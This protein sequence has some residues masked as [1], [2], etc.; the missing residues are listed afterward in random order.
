M[1]GDLG[2]PARRQKHTSILTVVLVTQVVIALLTATAVYVGW[3]HLD[4]NLASGARIHHTRTK[5]V[6][7]QDRT[8]PSE[9][10]NVLVLGTD[11]RSGAGDKLDGEAGCDCS[12]TTIL[13]HV[14]AD[15]RSAYGVSIP[16]DALVKPVACTR[17]HEYLG[18]GLV[19]WN[20]AYS[21]GGP[22]CVADQLEQDFHVY[23]DDY[24]V[25][26]FN[27]FTSMVDAI[28]GVNVCIPFELDDPKYAKVDFKPGPSVH[29]DGTMAL[30]Y[31]RLRH[32]LAGT[33]IGRIRRQQTFVGA[34]VDELVSAGTLSRPDRLYRFADALTRS[35]T[36][37]PG[38]AHVDELISLAE[39]FRHIDV[40]HIRF[41]TLPNQIY[42]VPTSDVRWGR[43]Q[44]LPTAYRLMRLVG[45]DEP[46][47]ALAKGS[48][49]AGHRHRPP[50]AAAKAAA[51]AA[52]VCA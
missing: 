8:L 32:V 52:G 48:V 47:G 14:S 46:L 21:A 33:D 38:I 24:V 29:L 6:P 19:E 50:S 16:R 45:S 26:D 15:R 41:I 30:A 22:A 5:S 9:P 20:Q 18:T 11:S 37:D 2:E 7:Q 36:T 44:V 4:A 31:V 35:I 13:V 3:H 27:G 17:D 51:A 40:R 42:D 34:M 28:G 23:V 10:L 49:G 12:D 25:L 1:V 43:V 39:Q